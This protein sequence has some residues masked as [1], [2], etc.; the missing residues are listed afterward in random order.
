MAQKDTITG[1]IIRTSQ[2]QT[3]PAQSIDYENEKLKSTK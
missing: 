2:M 3:A 1:F